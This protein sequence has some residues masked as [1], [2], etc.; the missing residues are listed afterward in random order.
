MRGKRLTTE[1]V[2]ERIE[3][4]TGNE[5]LL[6][7]N[8]VNAHTKILIKHNLCRNTYEVKWGSFQQGT[9]CPRCFGSEK[10]NNKE[11][12]KRIFELTKNEYIRIGDYK[13]THT[14]IQVK[15]SLCGTKYEV[16]WSS[17]QSGRRCPRC[18]ESKGE[19]EIS[20]ILNSLGIKYISQKRF[21]KCKYKKTLPFDFY[22]HDKKSKL[23]IEFDGEQHFKS[24]EYF[25]GEKAFR[26][27]QLRDQIKNDF[28]LSNNIP[29]LRIPYTEQDNIEQIITNKLKELNFI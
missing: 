8:Y 14:K 22:V 29:L 15:H 21:K 19:K 2:K 4:L 18:N 5:Y 12:D 9:R 26:D 27:T 1:E 6:L 16:T 7:G 11:I 17:F 10:L 25:G 28:A 24:V 20:D 13:G 3:Y 23:L